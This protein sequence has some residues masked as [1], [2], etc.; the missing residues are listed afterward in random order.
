LFR[1]LDAIEALEWL[2]FPNVV[3]A[4]VP[5]V[6]SSLVDAVFA[7]NPVEHSTLAYNPSPLEWLVLKC[8]L[9]LANSQSPA[10]VLICDPEASDLELERVSK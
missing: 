9:G 7:F 5:A 1:H 10:L 3:G 2:S 6:C 8:E 4:L